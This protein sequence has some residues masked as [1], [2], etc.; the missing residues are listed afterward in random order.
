M[1]LMGIFI[2]SDLQKKKLFVP[3]PQKVVSSG[4]IGAKLAW[5]C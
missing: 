3:T 1:M 5:R 2:V 4:V